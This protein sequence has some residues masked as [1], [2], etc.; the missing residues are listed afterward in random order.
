METKYIREFPPFFIWFTTLGIT[1]IL[2]VEGIKEL[3][4]TDLNFVEP[5]SKC[6]DG[7]GWVNFH[8]NDG[9]LF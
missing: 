4:P 8:I 2:G 6:C 7:R 9:F 5:Y 3:Y 1:K